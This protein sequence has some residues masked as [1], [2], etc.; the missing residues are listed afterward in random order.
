[1]TDTNVQTYQ[2]RAVNDALTSENRIHSD[3]IARRYGFSG[4]LVSGVAV[5]GHL[6]H[7][8]V[9][10]YGEDWLGNTAA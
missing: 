2:V 1:M 8:L 4:A 7:P 5:L 10:A 9:E 3:E 6:V